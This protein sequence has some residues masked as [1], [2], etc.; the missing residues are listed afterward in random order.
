MGVFL[1]I[2]QKF[3]EQLDVIDCRDEYFLVEKVTFL[4]MPNVCSHEMQLFWND[5]FSVIL[6]GLKR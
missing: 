5:V 6:I 4:S 2:F 3:S 1:E